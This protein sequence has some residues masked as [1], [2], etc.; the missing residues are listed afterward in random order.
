MTNAPRAAVLQFPG[1]NCE[2]E[3]ARA[4]EAAGATASILRWNEDQQIVEFKVMLRPL[5]AI[6]LIHQNMGE[7]LAAAQARTATP[8]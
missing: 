5:K 3:S 4:L 2:Y 7:M 1:V 6:Q 8:G